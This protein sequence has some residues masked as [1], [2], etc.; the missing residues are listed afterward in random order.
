MR[1]LLLALAPVVFAMAATAAPDRAVVAS[2]RHLQSAV[3]RQPDDSDLMLLSSLRQLR[4]PRM[5]SFFLQLAQN[6]R[7]MARIHAILGLAEIDP[8][9]H[10]DPW[11]ISRLDFPD[12][13]YAT[14]EN[15]IQLDLIDTPQMKELLGWDDLEAKSRVLLY[16]EIMTRDEPVD[17]TALV[18][19]AAHTEMDIAGLAACLLAQLGDTETFD[20]YRTNLAAAPHDIRNALLAGLW[21]AIRVYELTATL[22]W[23]AETIDLGDLNPEVVARGVSTLLVLDPER[24]A[25]VWARTLG[26]DPTY[27]TTVRYALILLAAGTGVPMSA[28]DR[29]PGDDPLLGR[30]ADAGRA[31]ASGVDVASHLI[32]LM[33]LG[34]AG[35]MGGVMSVAVDLDDEQA[36]RLYGHTI[37][38]LETGVPHSA[39]SRAKVAFVAASRLFDI[40][41]EALVGRLDRAPDNSLMQEAILLGLLESTSPD[42]ATAARR[43]NRTGFSRA[44]SLATILIAKH[45]EQLTPAELQQLGVIAAGGGKISEM[46][47]AQA[48]WLYLRHADRIEQ[49]LVNVFATAAESP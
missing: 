32:E 35:T 11:L 31:L 27:S 23:I 20:A 1:R 48:A 49:A 16:A 33:D 39:V 43:V 8:S 28:Y 6:G 5:R 3:Q 7:P 18:D 9:G 42:A 24:G 19:L 44:D 45:S 2:T 25:A 47:R 15:A 14:V 4:D 29:L 13:R 22:D 12:A 26:A 17:R 37:D 36:A 34:H 30:M 41:P 38:A 10:I 40:D 21:S 46:L